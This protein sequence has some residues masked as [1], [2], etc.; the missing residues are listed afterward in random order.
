MNRIALALTST[1]LTFAIAPAE[2]AGPAGDCRNPAVAE[3]SY[4]DINMPGRV[5]AH[6]TAINDRG[7]IVGYSLEDDPEQAIGFVLRDGGFTPLVV[8][9]AFNT[10]PLDINNA[11][12]IV[13]FYCVM[14][15]EYGCGPF[16]WRNG[17][18]TTG[19]VSLDYNS[20][21]SAINNAGTMVGNIGNRAVIVRHGQVEDV[22]PDAVWSSG[23]DLNERGDV[24][25]NIQQV[26]E[27]VF[28]SYLSTRGALRALRVCDGFPFSVTRVTNQR[29][30]VG[31]TRFGDSPLLPSLAFVASS[32]GL[33]VYQ[34]PGS[35]VPGGWTGLRDVN[36][37]GYAVGFRGFLFVPA[38]R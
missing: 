1:V 6:P 2:G 9:G 31:W 14:V 16:T 27:P 19:P 20:S 25:L 3:G 4:V 13:G 35:D 22:V 33:A 23:I 15:P 32:R 12:V 17:E 37:A 7:D 21:L 28:R 24:L 8:P 26:G 34:Y 10:S 11:G 5:S 36:A 38:R 30:L 29:E 18:F